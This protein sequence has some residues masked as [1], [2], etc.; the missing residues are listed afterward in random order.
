MASKKALAFLTAQGIAIEHTGTERGNF[1]TGSGYGPNAMPYHIV[2]MDSRYGS[3]K[4]TVGWAVDMADARRQRD[5]LNDIE[6]AHDTNGR[7]G[8]EFMRSRQVNHYIM[9]IRSNEI[10]T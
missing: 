10:V 2:R 9:D 5:T 3:S 7:G 6:Y 8:G 4:Q 1:A